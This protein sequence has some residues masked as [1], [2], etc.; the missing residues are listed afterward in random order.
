M[1]ELWW[2]LAQV[3]GTLLALIG[4]MVLVVCAGHVPWLNSLVGGDPIGGDRDDEGT[5]TR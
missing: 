2:P 1:S 5:P 4:V 3:A